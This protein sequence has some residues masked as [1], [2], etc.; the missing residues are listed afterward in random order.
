MLVKQH[1][2]VADSSAGRSLG[3]RQV[4]EFL[5]KVWSFPGSADSGYQAKVASVHFGV[6]INV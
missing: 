5:Q 3:Y 4:L 6:V 1:G 2:L